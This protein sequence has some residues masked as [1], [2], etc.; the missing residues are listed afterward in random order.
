MTLEAIER[1]C[2]EHS[3]GASALAT[4]LEQQTYADCEDS[5]MLIGAWEGALLRMIVAMSGARRVLEI[6]T[7]TGYSALT[8]AEALPADGQ[9]ITCD[10]NADT[11][12]IAQRFFDRSPHGRKIVVRL[13]LALDTLRTLRPPFDL[14]F[15]DADKENYCAYFEACLGL[16]RPNGLIVADNVLWSGRVLHPENDLD[17]AIVAFNEQVRNDKRVECVMLPIRDGVSV[18]RKL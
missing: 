11:S 2:T 12:A 13:G 16:L 1:Y 6:G 15:I 8:M 5:Q 17:R 7:F 14:A 10:V 4:E 18:I 3:S 9:I